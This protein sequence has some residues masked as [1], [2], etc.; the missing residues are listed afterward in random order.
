MVNQCCRNAHNRCHRPPPQI[1]AST[2][3]PSQRL[4]KDS[5]GRSERFHTVG[6]RPTERALVRL[7]RGVNP[8]LQPFWQY[9]GAVMKQ[10]FLGLVIVAGSVVVALAG[11]P[12]SCRDKF[13]GTWKSSFGGSTEVHA[14]GTATPST[15]VK[16]QT[17]TCDGDKYIFSNP[18]GQTWTAT[19]S[20]DGNKLIGPGV[21]TRVGAP[22]TP[23]G[24]SV[25]KQGRSKET[26][27]RCG[28]GSDPHQCVS[29]EQRGTSGHWHN[30]RLVN[31]CNRR[32]KVS[33]SSC[34]AKWAGGCKVEKLSVG[35]CET[36]GSANEGKQSWGQ[37]AKA[38]W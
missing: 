23:N 19:L 20:P 3:S 6:Q 24:G 25:G 37:D 10:L 21:A 2:K 14:D 28:S 34:D 33:V 12:A 11:P 38:L 15:G 17:W 9:M 31:T 7:W 5:P 36:T 13:V 4:H 22:P 35:A 8:V 27:P 29:L 26:A 30:Y 1:E 18:D 32:F 16:S